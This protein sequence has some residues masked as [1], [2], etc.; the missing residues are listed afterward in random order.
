MSP[1]QREQI[2]QIA[3]SV[4]RASSSEAA[5]SCWGAHPEADEVS[6]C[7]LTDLF[8]AQVRVRLH[9]PYPSA[10]VTISSTARGSPS[11]GPYQ[12]LPPNVVM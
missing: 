5:L 3:Q 2:E 11:A 8:I 6:L 7:L 1:E 12:T 4:E 9:L 10:P